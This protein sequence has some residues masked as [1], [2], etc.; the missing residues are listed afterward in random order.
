MAS[1]RLDGQSLTIDGLW[2]IAHGAEVAIADE[3]RAAMAKGRAI[4]ERHLK[5][6]IPVY[7]LNTG[8]GSKAGQA[9][10]V[11]ALAGFSA[12][13]VRGRAQS[14]GPLLSVQEVRAVMAVRLNTM[15]TGA[16]GASP[17]LAD[18]LTA[19]LNRNVTPSVPRIGSIGASDLIPMATLA[20]AVM[21][22]FSLAP[23]DG[24]VLSSNTAFT[25]GLATMA[26]HEARRVLDTLQ[27]AGALT[28]TG[29][30]GNRTP[31]APEAL[32]LRNDRYMIAAGT[33]IYALTEGLGPARRLQDPLSLRCMAQVH[34]AA[35]GELARLDDV[36]T[37]EINTAS[38]NPAVILTT[39]T[40]TGTANF[41]LPHLTL[42]L[43]GMA[44]ALAMAAN[45][46]ISRIARLMNE[47]ASGLPPL[48]AAHEAGSAGFGPLM[49]P[50]EA[51]R[52]EIIHLATPVPILPSQ[53]ADGQEDSATFAALSAQ[54]LKDLIDR[55]D[56]LIAFE[57][58]AAAQAI[59]LAQAALPPR[60]K[61]VHAAIRKIS[62]VMREDRPMGREIEA[63]AEGLVA[64]GEAVR[65]A[66]A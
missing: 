21:D 60:L 10:P 14:V 35:Y 64:N 46:I 17:A 23:K 45:E 55:L 52:A 3:A 25:A 36:V 32:R 62:A 49:K 8:L 59:D 38:D 2:R 65:L 27:V 15:L 31:F 43:D 13:V 22:G 29:F 57:L 5:E 16:A 30:R 41:H 7:G 11:E 34:G 50:A 12:Q 20:L 63:I 51:L 33:E 42:A 28:L 1:M 54:K 53:N 18:R 26:A 4:V 9:L 58:V 24:L 37:A 6:S 56:L 39:G 44:R 61:P 19:M 66:Q 48:L 40:I 47:A